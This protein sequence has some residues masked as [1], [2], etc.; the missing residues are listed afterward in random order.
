MDRAIIETIA[1]FQDELT[2]IRR[3]LHAHPEIGMEEYRTAGIVA[4]RL[5]EW[6][7]EVHRGVG[8]TGVVGILRNGD[9][10]SIGLRADMDALPIEEQ[11]NLP[12]A[13]RNPGFMH[14]CG[15]DGH[16]TML[17]AAARYLARSRRF[18]GT[19]TFIFQPGEEGCG[20]ARAMLDDGLFERFPCDAV[21]GMHNLPCLPEGTCRVSPGP[22]MAGG[23]RF[24][25][26][27]TGK[28]GH[29][30]LP[31]QTVDPL[32]AGCHI[33]TALQSIISR[34]MPPRRWRS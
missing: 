30:A 12:Y 9:G 5:G 24:D 4:D 25:I 16:T 27:V 13:S 6:G 8:K 15:D 28:G 20:G 14:A 2:A 3:D 23:A 1:E 7:I 21:F 22:G 19:V 34:N 29:G 11:T 17:L 33:A 10:P 31:D 18:R 26:V 32:I